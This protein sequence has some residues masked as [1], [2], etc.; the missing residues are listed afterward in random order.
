M[1]R[2][3]FACAQRTSNAWAARTSPPLQFFQATLCPAARPIRSAGGGDVITAT[4]E[5]AIGGSPLSAT[6]FAKKFYDAA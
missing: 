6:V 1:Q 5:C 3:V 4:P 2:R